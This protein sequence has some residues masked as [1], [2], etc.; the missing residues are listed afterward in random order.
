M[1]RIALGIALVTVLAACGSDAESSEDLDSQAFADSVEASASRAA[2][3]PGSGAA[4]PAQPVRAIAAGTLLTFEVKEDVSTSSHAAGATFSLVLVDAVTGPA[5]ASLPA[6]ASARGVVT[7]SHA[8]TGPDDQSVLGLKVSTVEAGGSQ[9]AVTGVAQ[10]AD[11]QASSRD[12]GT[13]TAATIAT[14]AAAG[15]IVGQIIGRDTRSTVTGAAVG[16]AVGVGVALTNRGGH[17]ELPAGSRIVVRL[18]QD[19]VF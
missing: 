7:D 15:A 10:S 19:L 4:V 12:S 13:R 18:S 8:S 17:A 1:N 2:A 5:G 9:K 6:G 14:G 11:I 3:S 16:A